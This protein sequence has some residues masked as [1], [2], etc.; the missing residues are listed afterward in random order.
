MNL[1]N[2]QR[3]SSRRRRSS[4][5]HDVKNVVNKS[6]MVAAIIAEVVVV[7]FKGIALFLIVKEAENCSKFCSD[8]THE[9]G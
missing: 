3:S 7:N 6:D 5:F 4:V 9:R 8:F 1:K 2:P